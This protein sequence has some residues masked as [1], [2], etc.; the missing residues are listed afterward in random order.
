MLIVA[1]NLRPGVDA[2]RLEA[3][4]KKWVPELEAK[5]RFGSLTSF[6]V[7]QQQQD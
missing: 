7:V 6:E 5:T 1:V 2:H 4:I 3:F